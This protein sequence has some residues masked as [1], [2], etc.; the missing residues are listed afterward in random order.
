MKRG[1]GMQRG[2][3]A[4]AAVLALTS[5]TGVPGS[6]QPETI[7]ALDTGGSG[8][9]APTPPHLNGGPRDIVD[10]FLD[11]NATSTGNHNTARKYLT[12]AAGNRWSDANATIIGDDLTES[13]YNVRTHTVTVFARVLGTLSPSGIYTPSLLGGGQGGEK[14]PFVFHIEQVGAV[15]RI[16]RLHPGLLLTDAQF[17]A[18]YRQEPLYFYDLAEDTL[19]PDLRWSA[20]DDRVQLSEW[21]L[22][23]LILGP[24]PELQ[25]AVSADTFPAQADPQQVVVRLGLPTVIDIPGSSRLDAGVRD[26]LAA[27]VSQTLVETLAG[28]EMTITDGP[29]PVQIPEIGGSLFTA[30]DFP[31]ALG[32]ALPP[33]E[34]FYLQ[35]GRIHDDSGKAISGPLGDGSVFL[36]SVA[37]S[38]PRPR[39][40]LL[41]AGVVGPADDARLEVGTQR[42]G[43]RRT[44]VRGQLCRPAFVPGRN[45]VWVGDGPRVYRVTS[46]QS[47]LHTEQVQILSRGGRVVAL[48]LSPE[49]SR[50]AVVISG[51]SG[52]T[53]LYIGSV[54]R[55]AGA[56]RIDS[57]KPI[58]PEGVVV[59]DV[60][61]L[62]SFK[63]FAIGYLAGSQDSKTFET[64]VDGTDWTNSAIG[65][66]PD[67]P[68]SVTAATFSTV[69]VSS[70]NGYVWKQSGNSWVSAGPTGQTPGTAPVYLE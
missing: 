17:R 66:L 30:S 63:L 9:V 18:T 14:Q 68:D 52:S 65:N 7:K 60:A 43:L 40:S 25:N 13:T 36:N 55:G 31:H 10:A 24:R 38:Q 29:T 21:L 53:Q 67:P 22:A 16:D 58:S 4:V 6:S 23:Q 27:Q 51:A 48:R 28:R 41:I 56:V 1:R 50:V 34:V 44:P 42:T 5:C 26:R 49:G 35:N 39:A 8:A 12:A 37:L 20:L 11:A 69:W 33:S 15:Y 57:L 47:G 45:E 61:W 2:L 46:D 70:N 19:V 59:Q 3:V 32:P 62:D 54:V 64:G